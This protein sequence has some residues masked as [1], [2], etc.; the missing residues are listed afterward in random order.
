MAGK[1]S[2]SFATPGSETLIE[3][4]NNASVDASSEPHS[5]PSNS[6]NDSGP[7]YR[8]AK[9]CVQLLPAVCAHT[10]AGGELRKV[11]RTLLP[12]L[13]SALG[14]L[15]PELLDTAANTLSSSR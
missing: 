7:G 12:L 8:F 6:A 15:A 9:A 14:E 5:Q 1:K 2:F 13:V 4:P 3:T 11:A 10:N